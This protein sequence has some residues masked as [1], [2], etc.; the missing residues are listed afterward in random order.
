MAEIPESLVGAQVRARLRGVCQ[1]KEPSRGDADSE[2]S[3]S[4]RRARVRGR[5][6][7]VIQVCDK[8][9]LFVYAPAYYVTSSTAFVKMAVLVS[10]FLHA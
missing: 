6:T 3:I 4:D 10:F 5:P 9:P 1:P 7:I 8:V 2:E